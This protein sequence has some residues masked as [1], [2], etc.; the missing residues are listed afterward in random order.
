MFLW[1][2]VFCVIVARSRGDEETQKPTATRAKYRACICSRNIFMC[3]FLL[4][5]ALNV[6]RV[7][8]MH[9]HWKDSLH[10]L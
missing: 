2:T 3:L 5:I 4:L 6:T 9:V 10:I 8:Y 7:R 1:Q